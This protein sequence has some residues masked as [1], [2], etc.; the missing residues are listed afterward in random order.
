MI[1]QGYFSMD[2]HGS[3][4]FMFIVNLASFVEITWSRAVDST[5]YMW[6]V[7]DK[8]GEIQVFE[9]WEKQRWYIKWCSTLWQIS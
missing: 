6:E 9:S 5:A 4:E 7:W 8:D 3:L 2:L 1:L